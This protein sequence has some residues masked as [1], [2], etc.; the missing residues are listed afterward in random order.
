MKYIFSLA[1]LL[2]SAVYAQK[3]S[4]IF[5]HNDYLQEKP[6]ETAYSLQVGYVEADVFLRDNN[7]MVAHTA[8]EINE[9]RTL[10]NLYLEPIRNKIKNNSGNIFP[11]V[12]QKLTLMIDLKSEGIP[13]LNAIVDHLKNYKE[14]TSCETLTIAISG[15]VPDTS[16]WKQFP[17]FITF[18]GRP[19]RKYSTQHLQRVSFIS[20]SFST[21]SK[22]DGKGE[23]PDVDLKKIR[24]VI[25]SVHSQ[26]KKIRFWGAPDVP[27]AW[28]RF[29]QLGVDIIGTDKIKEV[30]SFLKIH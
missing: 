4:V 14:I 11:N 1:F 24:D 3:S 13:T 8:S 27:N 5:S 18:D 21:Y 22:W 20:N 12:T 2:T 28:K 29:L 6:F 15:N 7:L 19:T 23:I 9:S 25:A 17:T 10:D 26:G 16:Q 30:Q